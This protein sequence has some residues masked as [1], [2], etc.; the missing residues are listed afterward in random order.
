MKGP[1]AGEIESTVIARVELRFVEIQRQR[2]IEDFL[3]RFAEFGQNRSNLR[4]RS[5]ENELHQLG[6]AQNVHLQSK[7]GLFNL[8]KVNICQYVEFLV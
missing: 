4:R 7:F 6:I 2:Q 1:G 8:F 3:D 5:R